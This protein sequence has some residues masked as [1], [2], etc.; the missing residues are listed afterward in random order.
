MPRNK[1]TIVLY[2]RR[3][4]HFNS[5]KTTSFC[6][7]QSRKCRFSTYPASRCV[8]PLSIPQS[9]AAF[10]ANGMWISYFKTFQW[11]NTC[12]D[13]LLSFVGIKGTLNAWPMLSNGLFLPC[14]E[15]SRMWSMF[16]HMHDAIKILLHKFCMQNLWRIFMASC[17]WLNIL[18]LRDSSQQGKNKP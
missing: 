10:W 6:T 13:W 15:L 5:A 4:K 9:Q 2:F 16:N 8:S 17:I 18:H 11:C 3:K 1:Q 14:C 12:F 7:G